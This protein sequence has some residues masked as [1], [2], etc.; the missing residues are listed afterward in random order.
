MVVEQR[1]GRV[2]RFGQTREVEL[3]NFAA[4]G[5]VESHILR[6][7]HTKIRL[8][9]LVVGELDLILDQMKED[10]GD[11]FEGLLGDMWLKAESDEEFEREIDVLGDSMTEKRAAASAG[12][13]RSTRYAAEDP[14]GRLEAEFAALPIPARVRLG[15]GTVKLTMA[16]GVESSRQQLGVHVA[17]VIEI[18]GSG[19]R[20]E[21]GTR[22]PD[23]GATY[24]ITG[25][26]GQGRAL[27]LLVQADRLPLVLVEL[28]GDP[29]AP[30]AA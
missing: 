8:F 10:D 3:F 16:P 26:T 7:L 11:G 17:E 19:P 4:K 25:V 5:T 20:V 24:R 22:H 2:H 9:E 1:I 15:Y 29:A 27:W 23:Y 21:A 6:L 28:G 12:E 30:L 13:E 14:A 18:L